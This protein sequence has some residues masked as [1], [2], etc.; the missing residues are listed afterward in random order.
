M[1]LDP[2]IGT[3]ARMAKLPVASPA[4]L[5]IDALTVAHRDLTRVVVSVEPDVLESPAVVDAVVGI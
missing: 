5:R 1:S 4:T 2:G 3:C